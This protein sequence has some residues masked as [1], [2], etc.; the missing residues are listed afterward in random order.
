MSPLKGA[1]YNEGLVRTFL[2]EN[3][4]KQEFAVELGGYILFHCG[5]GREEID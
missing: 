4:Q 3:K 5:P 2:P 1:T